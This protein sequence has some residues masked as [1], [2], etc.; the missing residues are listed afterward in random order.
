[1]NL[2]FSEMTQ[3]SPLDLMISL[4]SIPPFPLCQAPVEMI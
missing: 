3:E 1:M 4:C 2:Q